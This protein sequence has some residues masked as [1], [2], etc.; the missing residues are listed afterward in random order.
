MSAVQEL[1]AAQQLVD[2]ILASV[3]SLETAKQAHSQLRAEG[4]LYRA[5]ENTSCAELLYTTAKQLADEYQLTKGAT[6]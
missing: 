5:G 4:A 2:E 6:T 3:T 1:A